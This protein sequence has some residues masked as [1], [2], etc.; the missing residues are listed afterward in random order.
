MLSSGQSQMASGL[1]C[2]CTACCCQLL[3]AL[4]SKLTHGSLH[5]LHRISE[6]L[7]QH[8]SVAAALATNRL[9][10]EITACVS[11]ESADTQAVMMTQPFKDGSPVSLPRS[12][13]PASQ[14]CQGSGTR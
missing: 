11:G 12:K 13:D 14:T 5:I 6:C 1:C 4:Y 3:L 10:V 8:D 2:L 9:C 7:N